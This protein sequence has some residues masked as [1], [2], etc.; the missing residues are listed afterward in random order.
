MYIYRLLIDVRPRPFWRSK[1]AIS[2]LRHLSRDKRCKHLVANIVW[3]FF[4][5]IQNGCFS[6]FSVLRRK[7]RN[8]KWSSRTGV[9]E[10]EGTLKTE[11][12]RSKVWS[13]LSLE[14]PS[15]W[16][17]EVVERGLARITI[18]PTISLNFWTT[19]PFREVVSLVSNWSRTGRYVTSNSDSWLL[20]WYFK[21]FASC[22]SG[23]PH[24]RSSTNRQMVVAKMNKGIAI[25]TRGFGI[26]FVRANPQEGVGLAKLSCY[27]HLGFLPADIQG[28]QIYYARL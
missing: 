6:R 12:R 4:S 1:I 26:L 5:L 24:L 19:S 7:S 17:R 27:S 23:S 10:F 28:T 13:T 2:F 25:W 9:S 20:V 18:V 3:I 14:M 11:W 8:D 21:T 16:A 15:S 22:S